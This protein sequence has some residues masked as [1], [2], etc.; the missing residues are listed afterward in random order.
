MDCMP[1]FSPTICLTHDCNLNCVYCYQTHDSNMRMTFATA[2]TCIDWIFSNVPDDMCSIEIGFIG[3]EPLLE[4]DLIKRIV[5]YTNS[6]VQTENYIFYATTNGTLLTSEMKEWFVSHKHCCVLG[7]SLDGTPETHNINRCN[8]FKD[9]DISFFIDTW[10][11][12]GVK[13]TLTEHSLKHL[14]E[15]IKYIHSLGFKEING[16]NLFEGSFDWGQEKYIGILIP[17]LEELVAF[18]VDNEHLQV[19]QML[20]RRIELCEEK[21]RAR[22]KWCGVGTGAIFFDVDG[23]RLP[24]PFCS[25]MTFD[26]NSMDSISKCDYSSADNFIDEGCFSECYIYPVCPYCAAANFLTQGT[27]K[28]RDKSKC[29][30]QKL[31]TLFSAD[32]EA[33]RILKNPKNQSES[34]LFYKISAIEKVR[35]LYLT[36]F[37]T[38]LK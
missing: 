31:I 22:K 8:S 24:C 28:T 36:E 19:N 6:R 30:I 5:E 10:P 35:E 13:M 17:Q 1:R 15:D 18:Y 32:L 16:V 26:E 34:E 14:A 7:L 3:G 37:E 12:Q 23:A 4:F 21:N 20:N 11:D 27:F 9:I 38:Y 25:P 29:R 2:K 33:K